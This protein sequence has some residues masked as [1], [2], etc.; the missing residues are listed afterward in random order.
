VI[1]EDADGSDKPIIARASPL[2]QIVEA[3]H[4]LKSNQQRGK[5]VVIV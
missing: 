1:P 5:I 3:H 2:R 4:Y